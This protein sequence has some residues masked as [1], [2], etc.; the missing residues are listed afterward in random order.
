M[1]IDFRDK[2]ENRE[3]PYGDYGSDHLYNINPIKRR[4]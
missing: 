3:K 2:D 4:Y 1:R